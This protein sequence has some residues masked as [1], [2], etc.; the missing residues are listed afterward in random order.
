MKKVVVIGGGWAGCAAAISAKKAGA[1]VTL[2][3]RT[4]MVLGLGNVGGI[5][6]NNGRYTAA[7]E[8]ILLG[9]RELFE[10]TDAC[11]RH[12]DIDFPG[13]KHASLYDVNIIEGVVRRKLLEMKINLLLKSRVVDAT[14]EGNTIKSV[15]L[16]NG[17]V[18]NGDSFVETTGTTGPMGNCLRYG[19]GC[20]MCVL[21]C[22]SF[23]P[24]VSITQKCGVKDMIGK[25]NDGNY[26]AF[27][28]SVKLNKESLS[29]EI[30]NEL[31]KN[32]LVVIPL[33]E[34][35]I[36]Q[37][38]LNIK[39]C[40]QYALEAFAKNLIL[41]DTGHAK[42]MVPYYPLD[43]LRK[44]EGFEN[45][46]YED[47]Y[48]GGIGNSIR[49]LSVAKRN[50]N[51]KVIGVDNLFVAGEKSGFYVGHTEAIVTGYLAGHNSVKNALGIPLL[52]LPRTIAIGDLVAYGNEILDSED[53]DK[54]KVTFAGSV[55]FERMKKLGLYT[56]DKN[57]L[58]DKIFKLGLMN[59]YDEKII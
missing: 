45:A 18:I 25:R 14:L 44:I 53:G 38:K 47:P 26:G 19:N 24:R 6:R 16:E 49:Y 42:L 28:G 36:N 29:E 57:Y 15:T 59:V 31:N 40:Q 34:E 10:I 43:K 55:Y 1:D 46:K 56:I 21:R 58:K 3:E 11:S 4:D 17:K 32:G 12:K 20:A 33:P 37:G 27:S 9:G 13:H 39:V 35:E 8:S 41:L 22:P 52:E 30:R 7:E 50:N 54:L 2:I 48:S 51:L 23:G 5:M